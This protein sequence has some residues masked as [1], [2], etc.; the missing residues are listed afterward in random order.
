MLRIIQKTD[1]TLRTLPHSP[2]VF[3]EALKYVLRGERCFHVSNPDGEDYDLSYVENDSLFVEGNQNA[4]VF[5]SAV[6]PPYYFYDESD[7]EKIDLTVFDGSDTVLFEEANEYTIVIAKVLKAMTSI[8]V[9]FL[10]ERSRFFFPCPGES[11]SEAGTKAVECLKADSE[12]VRRI[13]DAPGTFLCNS[14]HGYNGLVIH[15]ESVLSAEFLFHNVFLWQW[16]TDLPLSQI[17]YV[18]AVVLKIE[19]I[20]AVLDHYARM[21]HLFGKKGIKTYLR[22]GAT[23]FRD[24]ML[25]RFFS[26]ESLP[27]DADD[28]N[29]IFL[30]NFIPLRVSVPFHRSDPSFGTEMLSPQFLDEISSYYEGVF[31]G[32]KILGVLM[33]GTDYINLKMD[34]RRKHAG[35]DEIIPR[36]DQWI[37]EEGFEEIFLA[38]EDAD[39]LDRMKAYYGKSL[40]A[41]AQ[42]RYRLSDFRQGESLSDVEKRK[43][44]QEQEDVVQ[45]TVANYFYA[46]VILSKCAGFLCSGQCNGWDVVNSLNDRKFIRSECVTPSMN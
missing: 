1:H 25:E 3:H 10:D 41:I 20:G 19:G 26:F 23:R 6:L 37:R 39:I 35:P 45:D 46:L 42:E 24:S 28:S 9:I 18:S 22:P 15:G 21:K 38:T 13:K 17:R 4:I 29:T 8:R 33:R 27:E 34:G 7:R 5:D 32:R 43:S 40:V 11:G 36:I 14:A 31:R 44:G 30:E 2:G 12:E 16:M